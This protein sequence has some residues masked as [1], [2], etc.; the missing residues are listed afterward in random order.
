MIWALRLM[1]RLVSLLFTCSQDGWTVPIA[2]SQS[3]THPW[4]KSGHQVDTQGSVSSM[5]AALQLTEILLPAFDQENTTNGQILIRSA[6]TN[7]IT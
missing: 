2:F 1:D 5:P 4:H 3:P 7:R 6:A